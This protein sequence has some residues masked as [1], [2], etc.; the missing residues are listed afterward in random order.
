MYMQREKFL[1]KYLKFEVFVFPVVL[2]TYPT[3][4]YYGENAVLWKICWMLI[5]AVGASL[6]LLPLIFLSLNCFYIYDDRIVIKRLWHKK[7][8]FYKDTLRCFYKDNT[9]ILCLYL[10]DR[11]KKIHLGTYLSSEDIVKEL[12]RYLDVKRI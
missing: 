7:Q 9:Q 12:S 8:I 1:N 3:I 2:G 11:E 6:L 5:G 4:H 10:A